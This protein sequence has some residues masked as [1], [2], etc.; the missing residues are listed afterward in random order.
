MARWTYIPPSKSKF[1]KGVPRGTKIARA[2]TVKTKR[3]LET[4]RAMIQAERSHGHEGLGNSVLY[5][6][7]LRF[8]NP[9][10]TSPADYVFP[11]VAFKREAERAKEPTDLQTRAMDRY[12]GTDPAQGVQVS[13]T[14]RTKIDWRRYYP[15]PTPEQLQAEPA[16]FGVVR[17]RE[18]F[19]KERSLHEGDNSGLRKWSGR[20]QNKVNI[21]TLL[22]G[23]FKFLYLCF[24]G[25]TAFFV[26]QDEY[27]MRLR[28]S[29][30]YSSDAARQIFQNKLW[31][32]ITWFENYSLVK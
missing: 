24:S 6:R 1:A 18:R 12:F 3:Q 15:N 31:Y 10:Q 29:R 19:E 5:R 4:A 20:V 2:S 7:R 28:I 16:I 23:P 32:R 13:R 11:G 27:L 22:N 26:E 9:I 8:S 30:D 14:P 17:A 25:L 21:V